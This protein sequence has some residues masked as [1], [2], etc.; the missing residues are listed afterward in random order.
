MRRKHAWWQIITPHG[1]WHILIGTVLLGL[2]AWALFKWHKPLGVLP[3][4]L[5]LWLI[6]FFRDPP[7]LIPQDANVLV[8][9]ADGM[10]SDITE[11][12]ECLIL[13]E[14]ALRIGIFLSI[15][16]VH[17]N[18]APCA[19]TV[20]S[21]SYR[22]GKFINALNHEQA[23]Q[24]NESNTLVLALPGSKRPAVGVRQI[25]GL[26]ARTIVCEIEED[27]QLERG[28]RFGMIRFGSRTELYV[29]KRLGPTVK[30]KIKDKVKAGSDILAAMQPETSA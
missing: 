27:E 22:K 24:L 28:E 21:K 23:S 13:G 4:P 2:A 18:R 9:P 7:R 8:A 26:I 14:P 11:M 15:F 3:V 19:G 20:I 30:V 29:A 6:A 25:V 17:I 16:N 12:P 1:Q 10:I 5:W